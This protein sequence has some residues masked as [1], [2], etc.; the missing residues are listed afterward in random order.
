[1][2]SKVIE[3]IEDVYVLDGGLTDWLES[4]YMVEKGEVAYKP[5]DLS[6]ENF[7]FQNGNLEFCD[8]KFVELKVS[9]LS[10]K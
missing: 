1:M 8:K 10:N 7:N 5:R 4:G 2:V 9:E 3:L 6:S